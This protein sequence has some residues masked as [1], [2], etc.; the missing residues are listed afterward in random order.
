MGMYNEVFKRCPEC[1][2]LNDIQISQVELGFGGYYL[3]QPS[4]MYHLDIE[5][6][7]K[8][9]RRVEAE[10]FH[11]S[12]CGNMYKVE[13]SVTDTNTVYKVDI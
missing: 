10:D 5:D 1:G 4:T 3:D 11:C 6:K 12:G 2:N 8:L 7:N 9:K 13:V